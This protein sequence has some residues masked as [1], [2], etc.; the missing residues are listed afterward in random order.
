MTGLQFQE[1]VSHGE[2]RRI[3]DI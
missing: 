2:G 1:R 3:R